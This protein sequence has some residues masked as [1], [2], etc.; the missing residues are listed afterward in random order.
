[1][2][3]YVTTIT[4]T[5]GDSLAGFQ[6]RVLDSSGTIVDIFQ[7]ASGTSWPNDIAVADD[8][9]VVSFF[10]TAA[11]GQTLQF[12]D[13]TGAFTGRAIANFAD[14]QNLANC[15]GTLE[16]SAVPGIADRAK[17]AAVGITGSATNLG[18]FTSP[19]IDDNKT[20]KA[21][22][23]SVATN[24]A[25]SGGAGNVGFVQEG[26]G[27]VAQTL[28]GKARNRFDASDFLPAGFV[29]DGSVDYTTQIQAAIDHISPKGGIL[30]FPP[31]T[32][33]GNWVM[34][35]GVIF[36]GA[37]QRETRFIP[38]TNQHV[39]RTP[40]DVSTV[41]IGWVDLEIYGDLAHTGKNGIHLE[42]SGT[43]RFIDT[44]YIKNVGIFNNGSAGI[45]VTGTSF[46]GPFV[47]RMFIDNVESTYNQLYNLRCT[48][49]VIECEA[50]NSTLTHV[51]E[52]D[53]TGKPVSFERIGGLNTAQFTF[54]NCLFANVTALTATNFAPAIWIDG[55][56]NLNFFGC[57]AEGF[58]PAIYLADTAQAEG[59]TWIGGKFAVATN[60]VTS[61]IDVENCRKLIMKGARIDIGAGNTV[62]NI[63]RLG[64]NMAKHQGIDVDDTNY[65]AGSYT[66]WI[67]EGAS[68]YQQF[69]GT[70]VV[71][72]RPNMTLWPT[73][74]ATN[75]VD[76]VDE[77]ASTTAFRYGD[78][79]T[80]SL[81]S[82]T[83]P[84]TVKNTGNIQLAY[85]NDF[86]L[87]DANK[88]LTLMWNRP[89]AKW[90][91]V[92]RQP[93]VPTGAAV[94]DAT[95]AGDVVA[96]LNTLLARLR[97]QKIIAT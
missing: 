26:T 3:R 44:V 5:R 65:V 34:K 89:L 75:L 67:N 7:D 15:F 82:G 77:N 83:G 56:S 14:N 10:W 76:I 42:V 64:G 96:Q 79:L 95:G 81:F 68:Y 52:D 11:A 85:G 62:T 1:M 6:V 51:V 9:G 45:Y 78:T 33:K 22:L 46:D 94:A 70:S 38:A 49:V 87:D 72:Y 27:A 20:V 23:E 8:E 12:L 59:F 35:R 17:A 43:G 31:G 84:I 37:G 58:S 18:T 55:V 90:T 54:T 47:Q 13:S 92:S 73:G 4:N 86:A 2:N 39:F 97:A 66:N 74:G 28:L 61:I 48:G 71:Y 16:D 41:R 63:I 40:A 57:N 29:T 93:P 53:G 69:A 80:I 91:E 36:Q 25:S 24:L 21:A 30:Y 50:R 60:L 32:F 88:T 19:L